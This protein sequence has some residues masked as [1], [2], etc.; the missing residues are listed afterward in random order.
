MKKKIKKTLKVI[1]IALGVIFCLFAVFVIYVGRNAYKETEEIYNKSHFS[2]MAYF[3]ES[4]KRSYGYGGNGWSIDF[5]AF[6]G[7]TLITDGSDVSCTPYCHKEEVILKGISLDAIAA[8]TWEKRKI[9]DLPASGIGTPFTF[10]VSD[11]YNGK[12]DAIYAVTAI[13]HDLNDNSDN[14]VT[15]YIHVSKSI[16]KCCRV[17][18]TSQNR[19]DEQLEKYHE[20][21]DAL[22]PADYLDDSKLCYPT[23]YSGKTNVYKSSYSCAPD[24]QALSEQL[25]DESWPDAAKVYAFARYMTDNYAYDK[26]SG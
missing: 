13:F 26:V 17:T 24:Y 10:D 16:A 6:Y 5:E 18:D 23:T 20:I 1:L 2:D 11:L 19:I 3:D 14:S 25:V 15:G 21:V 12:F 22:N 9:R 4:S 7:I 8:D